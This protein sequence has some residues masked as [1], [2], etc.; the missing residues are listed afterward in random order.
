MTKFTPELLAEIFKYHPP[1]TEERKQKHEACNKA[2]M[3][4]AL[5]CIPGEP[6]T[7]QG[8]IS[9]KEACIKEL[10]KLVRPGVFLERSMKELAAAALHATDG[11]IAD[12]IMRI[13]VARM[14]INQAITYESLRIE[15]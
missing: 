13:Q 7:Q 8:L 15:L 12:A 4:F 6:E 9:S 1:T 3:D 5:T 11:E 2:T 14:L 10:S